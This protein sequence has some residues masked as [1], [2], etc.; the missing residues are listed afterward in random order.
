MP[1]KHA[2]RTAA[3][4]MNS[5]SHSRRIQAVTPLEERYQPVRLNALCCVCG[6]HRTVSSNFYRKSSDPNNNYNETGRRLG[7]NNT[8]TL[9][10]DACG[11]TTRHAI[12]EREDRAYRDWLEKQ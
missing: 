3:E 4:D 5:T 7:W 11:T 2:E 9:K 6:N 12:L 10:C 8:A 1:A